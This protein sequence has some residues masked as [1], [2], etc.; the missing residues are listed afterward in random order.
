M[1]AGRASDS[2]ALAKLCPDLRHHVV[3]VN[4]LHHRYRSTTQVTKNDRGAG[5]SADF[6]HGPIQQAARDV[7]DDTGAG[8]ERRLRRAR[9]VRVDGNPGSTHKPRRQRSNDRDH[10]TNLLVLLHG[11]RMRSRGFATYVDPLR[12]SLD[13][14]HRGRHGRIHGGEAAVSAAMAM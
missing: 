11:L 10:A 5:A 7:V 13:H 4:V 12:T 6:K 3:E 2:D 1:A 9:L 14:G 8:I